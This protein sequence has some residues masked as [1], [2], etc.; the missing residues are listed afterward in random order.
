MREAFHSEG[1]AADLA[2]IFF[3]FA[4]FF[5]YHSLGSFLSHSEAQGDQAWE[6]KP[7]EALLAFFFKIYVGGGFLSGLAKF[8]V[9]FLG[10]LRWLNF[11]KIFQKKIV[12]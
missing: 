9:A 4:V 7:P 8:E 11:F 6:R 2:R 1:R 12:S 10:G 3:L 5:E